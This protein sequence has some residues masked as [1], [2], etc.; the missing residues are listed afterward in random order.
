MGLEPLTAVPEPPTEGALERLSLAALWELRARHWTRMLLKLAWHLLMAR[1]A[2][3]LLMPEEGSTEPLPARPRTHEGPPRRARQIT[4]ALPRKLLRGVARA[5]LCR[6]AAAIPH[7]DSTVPSRPQ[8]RLEAT[9]KA[10][11]SAV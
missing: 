11:L 3:A 4:P 1:L 7:P 2:R 9:S 5:R 8:L 6:R 10:G